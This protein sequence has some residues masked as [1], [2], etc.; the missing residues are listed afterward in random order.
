MIQLAKGLTSA[1]KCEEEKH[2]F[3]GEDPLIC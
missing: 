1:V 3:K 2:V